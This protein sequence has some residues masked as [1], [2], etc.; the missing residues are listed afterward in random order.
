MTF[1]PTN[2]EDLTRLRR[3]IDEQRMRF[4]PYYD[5]RKVLLDALNDPCHKTEEVD[6]IDRRPHNPLDKMVR[7]LTRG[8]VD[9]E[10]T[11][12]IV[13]SRNARATGMLKEQL[14]S[15]AKQA[16]M[17]EVLQNVFQE[18]LLRWGIIYTGYETPEA[19]YGMIPF[20]QV[21]D[22]DDYFI[23]TRGNDEH[24]VDFEGHCWARRLDHIQS[25]QTNDQNVVDRL[26]E[27][28]KKKYR[29]KVT[30]LYTWVDLRCVWLPQEGVELTLVDEM[31]GSILEPLRVKK[32]V[33]PPPGPY[34]RLSLGNVRG[35]MVPVSRMSMLYDL[36]EFISRA[37]RNVYEQADES[38]EFYAYAGESERDA[39]KHRTARR[40]EYV[41]FD[42]PAGVVKQKKGGVDPGTLG[43]AIHA[44]DLFDSDAGN[45][46]LI[47][48]LGPS[49]P[50]LGQERGLGIG[51]QGM[52]DDM[53]S[54]VGKTATRLYETAAWYITHDPLRNEQVE[55]TTPNGN[56]VQ[57]DW[58]PETGASIDHD[59]SF[60]EIIPGSMVSRSAEGQLQFLI[61]SMQVIASSMALPG[62]EPPVFRHRR[63]RELVAELGN[64]PE[65]AEL[66]GEATDV[67]SVVP[68]V[69]QAA[70]FNRQPGRQSGGGQPQQ[71]RM[72]ERMIFSGGRPAE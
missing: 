30:T 58:T 23:D 47:G 4:R 63:F 8:V 53:K 3:V 49:A 34:V 50:T 70:Q 12:R 1:D 65:I 55:W 20:A 66:F 64:A 71:N 5:N 35:N 10:P 17:A 56:R 19:G 59:E 44:D 25:D 22:F 37:Y 36:H 2:T 27:S 52:I 13:K 38:N 28:A 33:G 42:N 43:T 7:I 46:K 18:A 72:A 32:Y 6:T 41:R 9:Q 61:Q 51:V 26:A 39:E 29:N 21:L 16:R 15:W 45:L 69:E 24:D 40:F 57:S 62:E 67:S 60:M 48:G 11:L 54:R 14:V 31:N 68:G